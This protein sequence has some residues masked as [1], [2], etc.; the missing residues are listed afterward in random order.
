MSTSWWENLLRNEEENESTA[1]AG[2][3]D[4][5]VADPT[6]LPSGDEEVKRNARREHLKH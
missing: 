4:D 2:L 5:S 1:M 6:Y 3:L